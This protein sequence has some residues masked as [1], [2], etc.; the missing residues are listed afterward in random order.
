MTKHDNLP[1]I[2]KVIAIA[3]HAGDAVLNIYNTD[4][5]V[6]AKSDQSPLTEADMASHHVIVA[7]LHDLEPGTP[8]LSEESSKTDFDVR[9]GWRRY[10]L[11]DPLDGTKEFVKR[12]GEFTVNIALI[13]D[14]VQVPVYGRIYYGIRGQGAWRQDRDQNPIPIRV[15]NRHQKPIRVAGSRSHAGESHGLEPAS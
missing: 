10:W 9:R 6:A 4:F 1:P 14:V 2:E 13:E 3:Q 12:N 8:V 7:G 11:V 5:A 15:Q